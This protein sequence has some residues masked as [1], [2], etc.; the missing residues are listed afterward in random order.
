M[1]AHTFKEPVKN[2]NTHITRAHSQRKTKNNSTAQLTIRTAF[3]F[4]LWDFNKIQWKIFAS[5]TSY[6]RIRLYTHTALC[7]ADSHVFWWELNARSSTDTSTIFCYV[8]TENVIV[9]SSSFFHHVAHN[10]WKVFSFEISQ[11][12]AC[13]FPCSSSYIWWHR[14]FISV[15][16]F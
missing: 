14:D 7:W 2:T 11:K 8:F 10:K 5:M 4:L 12:T 1:N 15:E 6:R 13:Y 3:N 9:S 16:Q